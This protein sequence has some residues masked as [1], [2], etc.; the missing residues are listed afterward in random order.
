MKEC[1]ESMETAARHARHE[2]FAECAK[3]H[4]CNKVLLA[5]HADDQA[6]T[7]L[8]NLLRGSY[9]LKGMRDEQEITVAG[10]KLRLI[11]PLLGLRHAALVAWLEERDLS[12]REDASNQQPVALRNRLRRRGCL[13]RR[14]VC[15]CL[16]C[17]NYRMFCNARRSV[18]IC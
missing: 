11:R 3:Q 8:W 2:F 10:R 5:H 7:V 14:G 6:E 12:W 4:R 16:L 9:G 1:G 18:I 13:I 15:T 17:G